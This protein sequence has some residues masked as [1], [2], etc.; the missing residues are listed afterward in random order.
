MEQIQTKILQEI[1]NRSESLNNLYQ[2]LL[3]AKLDENEEKEE[4]TLQNINMTL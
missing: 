4:E 3:I 2:T 1:I